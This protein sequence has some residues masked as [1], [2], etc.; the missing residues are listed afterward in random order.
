MAKD[1]GNFMKSFAGNLGS[2]MAGLGG[3]GNPAPDPFQMMQGMFGGNRDYD[4]TQQDNPGNKMFGAGSGKPGGNSFL[5]RFG[6]NLSDQ[7]FQ[8][9]M[10]GFMGR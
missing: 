6:G 5:A 4:P 9:A 7:L 3:A 2:Q 1:L 8:K 10:M